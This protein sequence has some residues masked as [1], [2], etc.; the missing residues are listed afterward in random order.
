MIKQIVNQVLNDTG[1]T[2]TELTQE[3]KTLFKANDKP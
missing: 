2:V 1:I 3:A